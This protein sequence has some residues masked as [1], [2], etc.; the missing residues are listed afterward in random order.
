MAG[1][2]HARRVPGEIDRGRSARGE[3]GHRLR[4]DRHAG[5]RQDDV[6]APRDILPAHVLDRGDDVDGIPLDH[7]ARSAEARHGDVQHRRIHGDHRRAAVV[8][9]VGVGE[10]VGRH[11]GV[12][13]QRDGRGVPAERERR[14]RAHREP[15]ERL[16]ADRHPG[17]RVL[18]R[19]DEARPH[20]LIADVPHRHAD[21]DGL[22]LGHR[23]GRGHAGQGD[24][25]HGH[26][27]RLHDDS[28]RR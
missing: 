6:E 27:R 21:V 17:R 19:D 18:Q 20:R 23:S 22:T 3:A 2:R 24:V 9:G 26:D 7:R 13:A 1:H 4:A 5:F 11:E 8:R 10:V 12:T 28:D 25:G 14:R 15:G 16:G